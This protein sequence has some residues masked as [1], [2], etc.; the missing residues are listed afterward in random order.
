MTPPNDI[1]ALDTREIEHQLT[2]SDLLSFQIFCLNTLLPIRRL[3]G[4]KWF[5]TV[6]SWVMLALW[7]PVTNRCSLE[8]IPGFAFLACCTQ[9]GGNT[10][11]EDCQKDGCDVLENGLY[12]TE[13]NQVKVAVPFFAPVDFLAPPAMESG[14][15]EALV[16]W[17][18]RTSATPEILKS[19]QF[20]FRAAAPPRAPSFAS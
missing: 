1:D 3:T 8:Q 6:M 13:S 11:D 5:T 12:K 9:E 7:L 14:A 10:Q 4:V 2:R 19:W 16:N 17:F 18:L 20:S 15:P